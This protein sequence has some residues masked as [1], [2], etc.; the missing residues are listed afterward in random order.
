MSDSNQILDPNG[1]PARESMSAY[2]GASNGFAGQLARWNVNS[3]SADA[4]LLPTYDLGNAR[5]ADLARNNGYAKSGV[6]LHID[7]I[8]GHQFKLVYKPNL[9]LLGLD[10]NSQEV[11]DFIKLVEAKFTNYAEDPR[12]YIDARNQHRARIRLLEYLLTV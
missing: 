8:V 3:K 11:S 6:Q 12:C 10:L 4:A 2:E 9:L 7:H 5:S 1:N